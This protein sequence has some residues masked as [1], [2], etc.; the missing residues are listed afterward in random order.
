MRAANYRFAD[1]VRTGLPLVFIMLLTLSLLL[2]ARYS[3]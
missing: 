1:F 2:A 3:A